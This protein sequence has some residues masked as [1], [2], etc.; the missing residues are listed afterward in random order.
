MV[1]DA[2]GLPVMIWIIFIME[3]NKNIKKD[4]KSIIPK[5]PN[6]NI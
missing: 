5:K 2:S 1:N 6:I 3:Q 4:K